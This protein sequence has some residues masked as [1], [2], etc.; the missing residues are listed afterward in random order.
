MKHNALLFTLFFYTHFIYSDPLLVAVLMVK[1]EEPV[2]ETTLQPLVD[3]GITDFLIYD[4]G[5]T[6]KTI[7]VT[8]D[9]F[10][11]NKISNFVIKQGEWIDFATSRNK[12]LELTEQHFPNATFM[13]MLDAEWILHNGKELLKYCNEQKNNVE[14]LYQIHIYC[15]NSKDEIYDDLA[16][17]RLFRCNANIKFIGKVHEI[18]NLKPQAIIPDQIYLKYNPTQSGKE[19]TNQRYFR[20]LKILLQEVQDN[21]Q[22]FRSTFFLAQ[23]YACLRNW[24]NAIKW[25]EHALTMP[26]SSEIFFIILCKLGQIYHFLD[27]HE[28][29]LFNYIRACA[30]C[31]QRA[32]PFVHL[33]QYFKEQGAYHLA[34]LFAQQ[35]VQKPYP[36]N[37]EMSIEKQ[38]YDFTRYELYQSM[39][40]LNFR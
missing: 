1:N 37:G 29:L 11:K 30:T 24:N 26:A 7:Q 3:A 13:L 38:L 18:P 10:I 40:S 6:D 8:Y 35:A 23:T 32:E 28:K 34:F 2:I 25:Y 22:D 21:P 5:S 15:L 27:N 16:L 33:A 4:T 9:F 12:A 19:K 39:L 36:S 17:P 31:P 20:D 14:T